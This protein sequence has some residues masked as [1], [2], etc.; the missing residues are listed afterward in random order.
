MCVPASQLETLSTTPSHGTGQWKHT[1]LQDPRNDLFVP[2][3]ERL[4]IG[5]KTGYAPTAMLE[6]T[7]GFVFGLSDHPI[8]AGQREGW[9]GV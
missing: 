6:R 1:Y 9:D 5:Q 3:S 8:T 4:L 7:K 2:S